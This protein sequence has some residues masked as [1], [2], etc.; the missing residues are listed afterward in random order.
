MDLGPGDF[1]LLDLRIILGSPFELADPSVDVRFNA[2]AGTHDG[3]AGRV[4][5]GFFRSAEFVVKDVGLLSNFLPIG[6]G[7]NSN[8]PPAR[9]TLL[10]AASSATANWPAERTAKQPA[11]TADW[12]K[13]RLDLNDIGDSLDFIFGSIS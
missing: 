11:K 3:D 12:K 13:D 2:S 10:G 8:L 9:A 1:L 4:V 5:F 6:R 7:R